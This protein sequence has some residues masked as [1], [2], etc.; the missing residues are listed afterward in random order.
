MT[1]PGNAPRGGQ[2]TIEELER[3]TGGD[4]G[5]GDVPWFVQDEAWARGPED[6]PYNYTGYSFDGTYMGPGW[7]A[8]NYDPSEDPYR[9]S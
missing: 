4:G 7:G 6:N 1:E 5:D 9:K 8:E 3:V 2:L